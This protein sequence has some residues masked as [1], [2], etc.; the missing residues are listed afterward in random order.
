MIRIRLLVAGLAVLAVG[1]G[2]TAATAAPPSALPSALPSTHSW[3]VAGPGGSA[4]SAKLDLDGAGELR[5]A[6]DRGAVPVLL[7]GRLGITTDQHQFTSGLAFVKRSDRTVRESYRM[8][9]GKRQA[10]TAAMQESTFTFR[11]ADG[12]QLGVVVRVAPDGVAYRYVLPGAGAVTVQREASAFEVPLD[13]KAWVQ[14]YVPGYENERTE[15]TAGAANAAE[16]K[17]CANGSCQFGYPTLFQIGSSYV[18]L[19]ESDVDGRYSGSKLSHADNSTS[20]SVEL[21]DSQPVTTTGPLSTPWRTA[22]VGTLDTVVG[23]TLVDDLA[24]ASKVT[25]T[26][27]IR[28]GVA[29]WSW[30]S[31]G[32]SPSDPSRQRDFVNFAAAHGLAYT[33]VDA[34]WNASWVPA[35]V[36]YARARGVNV[37]L[38]FAWS[39]LKTQAQRDAWLPRLKTWG[40]A[41]IKVDYMDSDS[42]AIFQWYDAI[43]ADTAR[44]KLMINFHGATPPRGL[45]RTWPQVMGVEAV[46]GEENGQ[47][48][49]RDVLL[50][51]T[52]NI[53]GSMDYTPTWFSRPGRKDSLG[54]ELALPVVFESAW[55][56][57]GDNPEGFAAQPE[58]VRYLE[59]LPTTWDDTRLV[60]GSPQQTAAG[61]RE[62]VV[63]RRNGSRWF[64]GG[65]LAGPAATMDAPLSFL[66]S[67]TWL[68]ETVADQG[69]ELRRAVR[70]VTAADRLSV[71]EPADGGFATVLCPATKGRTT[72]AQ[73]VI[74]PP[75]TKLTVLP[76]STHA[77]AGATVPVDAEFSLPSVGAL[78]TVRLA[79]DRSRLPHGWT[80][81]G[82]DRTAGTLPAGRVLAGHWLVTVPHDQTAAAV[83]VPVVA[84][85][86]NPAKGN[87]PV[88]VEDVATVNVAVHGDAYVSDLP[89]L[90]ES[91]GWGP[92]ERDQSNGETGSGDGRPITIAGATFA[93]G[94]GTN[95]PSEV[96][97]DLEGGCTAFQAQVGVDDEVSQPGSVTFTVNGDGKK[98]GST[99]VLHKG[100]KAVTIN[101][102]VTGVQTL[103]LIVGDGGDGA[104]FD[105]GDW[106]LAKLTCAN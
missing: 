9:A 8:I 13:A 30:L 65:L 15:T 98:L 75:L 32:N 51:F 47:N 55:T 68:A 19:T 40:V 60:A 29:D 42:Q 71:A 92:V 50:A 21:A 37:L 59:Q 33:L 84:T 12:A 74:T 48:P 57:L 104:A 38:W 103:Q 54:H 23:S 85:Y 99:G 62:V 97:V 10:R 2:A 18:L 43:L 1:G 66:G 27:W 34:G 6:V 20:W 93:K 4:L 69:G 101:A 77:A 63:A 94:L 31:N 72:C 16:P 86:A 56:H 82:A 39:D 78:H 25:D 96:D 36:R 61:N 79:V 70:Q 88:H 89:F 53:V 49:N 100:D 44:L 17:T 106:G 90:S 22:I 11:A 58:A 41:G 28:P 5:L 73:P 76:A 81:T 91:N 45:Q 102:D 14:P 105:H 80:V 35:L 83:D 24:P 7:P 26:S 95:A 52:R 3:A 87:A 46:R 67:G 64:V